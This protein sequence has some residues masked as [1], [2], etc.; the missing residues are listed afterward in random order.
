MI[1]N[2]EYYLQ[3]MNSYS[4]AFQKFSFSYNNSEKEI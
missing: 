1:Q 4:P 2:I 3:S